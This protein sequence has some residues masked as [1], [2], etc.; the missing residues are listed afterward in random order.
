MSIVSGAYCVH[1]YL[2][3]S[4]KLVEIANYQYNKYEHLNFF[5]VFAAVAMNL[6]LRYGFNFPGDLDKVTTFAEKGS[7]SFPEKAFPPNKGK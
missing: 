2:K 3:E 5:L 4:T 7:I 1:N 6:S